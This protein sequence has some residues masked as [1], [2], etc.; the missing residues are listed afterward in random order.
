MR[1]HHKNHL[2]TVDCRRKLAFQ[3]EDGASRGTRRAKRN[4]YRRT[5]SKGGM[6]EDEQENDV[7]TRRI[8]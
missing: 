2:L 3:D 7:R 5:K 6:K 4:R 1:S 8:R